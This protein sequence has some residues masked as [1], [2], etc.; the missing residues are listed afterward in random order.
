MRTLDALSVDVTITDP[1]YEAEA[2]TKRRRRTNKKAKAT[3]AYDREIAYAPLAFAPMTAALRAQA[4]LHIARTTRRW[5]LTFCQIEAMHLWRNA[6]EACGHT[7][8]R[9]M[10]WYKPD[11]Q[12]QFTGDRPSP[13]YE[14]I[15]LTHAPL[16][17]GER[18]AWNG[19][20]R[21]GVFTDVETSPHPTTK[22]LPLMQD[23]VDLFTFAGELVC[24]PFVGSG[25]TGIAALR[26]GRNF[27][28][29]EID[30]GYHNVA[31]ARLSGDEVN[32]DS[33]QGRLFAVA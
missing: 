31:R 18:M 15:V 3:S 9:T 8:V 20:G 19:G 14:C 29:W 32:P 12:P 17:K 21:K 11:G 27:I 16:K 26:A 24:D 7:Y 10:I 30:A 2:H 1:P 33:A 13:G 4:A 23:L 5:A 25:Q 6:F 22:P 28:G